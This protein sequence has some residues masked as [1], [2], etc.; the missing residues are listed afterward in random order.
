MAPEV[1][2]T[3][4]GEYF[5]RLVDRDALNAYLEDELGPADRFDLE[6]LKVGHSNETLHVTW[7]SRKMVMRRPPPGE[8]AESA[9]D[10]LREYRV[11]SALEGTDI[12]LPEPIL[13]CGDHAVIGSDF[14]LMERLQ[15]TVIRDEEPERFAAPEH[16]RTIGEE[17]MEILGRIHNLDYA[18]VGLEDLGHPEGFTERQVDRW[19]KQLDWAFETTA[20]VRTIPELREVGRWLKDNLPPDP[21]HTLFQGDYKLDNVMFAPGTPPRIVGVFDWEMCTLGDPLF[22]LG[23]TLISWRDEDD[24]DALA[25]MSSTSEFMLRE[26]Y[27]DRRGLVDLYESYSGIAFEHD[28]FYR[29]LAVYKYAGVGEMFFARHLAGDADDELYPLMEDIVPR[30]AEQALKIIRGEAPL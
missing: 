4:S 15:G 9:H 2:T 1:E 26:G 23:W 3:S 20:E 7:G 6:L 21:H 18:A 24:S 8:T 28:R 14:Y 22:D 12:P 5:E 16:R 30:L 10:V 19:T 17:L 25:G 11:L 29:A 27:P 13:A